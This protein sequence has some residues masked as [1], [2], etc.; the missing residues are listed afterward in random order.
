MR[1]LLGAAITLICLAGCVSPA[2]PPRTFIVF[3]NAESAEL[4]P[5]AKDI[6]ARVSAAIVNTHP[7]RVTIAGEPNTVTAPGY[8]PKLAEPRFIAIEQ[9]LIAAGVDSKIMERGALTDLEA[10][11]G[12]T[13]DRRVEIRL[14]NSD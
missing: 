7:A 5:T 10:K 11:V 12:A 9:A 1:S 8:D 2:Q 3:F 6:I 14:F 13:G 4:T